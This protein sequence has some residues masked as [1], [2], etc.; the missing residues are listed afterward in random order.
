MFAVPSMTSLLLG[1]CELHLG[2]YWLPLSGECQHSY[3]LT[4]PSSPELPSLL[5]PLSLLLPSEKNQRDNQTW[6]NK[7][8]IKQGKSSHTKTF[9]GNSTRGKVSQQEAKESKTSHIPQLGISQNDKLTVL[10][11]MQRTWCSPWQ[12][13]SGSTNLRE[14]CLV[15]S[16]G[17]VIL[18]SLIPS[19]SYSLPLPWDS[20][21]LKRKN[22]MEASNLHSLLTMPGC[23]SLHPLPYV[24][25]EGLSVDG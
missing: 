23:W 22:P 6:H 9:Q 17:C 24:A 15:H 25:R 5:D 18:V 19:D 2:S 21:I 11:Y 4:F 16:M 1:W 14:P 13:F 20:S 10:S 7:I 8:H 3:F 12:A